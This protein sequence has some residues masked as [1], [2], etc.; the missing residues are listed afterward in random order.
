MSD[1]VR[2]FV[3]PPL[4]IL[5]EIDDCLHNL[6]GWKWDHWWQFI[7]SEAGSGTFNDICGRQPLYAVFRFLGLLFC[8]DNYINKLKKCHIDPLSAV[9]PVARDVVGCIPAVIQTP[10]DKTCICAGAEFLFCSVPALCMVSITQGKMSN[11]DQ[12]NFMRF[13]IYTLI[14]Y[15]I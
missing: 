14:S 9:A 4:Y 10:F 2:R 12:S 5:R 3:T 15:W 6:G 8:T 13:I 11:W 1:W 7:T